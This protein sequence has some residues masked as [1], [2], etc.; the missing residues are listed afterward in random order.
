MKKEFL[1][2]ITFEN[3]KGMVMTQHVKYE[4]KPIQCESCKGIG[5]VMKDCKI[6]QKKVVTRQWRPKQKKPMVDGDGFQMAVKQL[7]TIENSLAMLKESMEVQDTRKEGEHG[8]REEENIEKNEIMEVQ[9]A[10]NEFE[11]GEMEEPPTVN[12]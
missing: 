4:W 10:Q 7:V 2:Y 8:E 5:H 6:Q 9:I 12:G 3:E 1:D 11:H